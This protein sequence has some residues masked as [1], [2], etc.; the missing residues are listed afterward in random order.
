MEP[1]VL[2]TGLAFLIVAMGLL[3]WVRRRQ[4][5]RAP[6]LVDP[7]YLLLFQRC[8]FECLLWTIFSV[9]LLSWLQSSVVTTT[10]ITGIVCVLLG[11]THAGVT[12]SYFRLTPATPTEVGS[13][14]YHH[15]PLKQM[16][17]QA[18]LL[19]NGWGWLII[20]I[21][22]FSVDARLALALP[23]NL[24]VIL[25]VA[26]LY[27]NWK[28]WKQTCYGLQRLYQ[29]SLASATTIVLHLDS[30]S[31]DES[32]GQVPA[33]QTIQ[34]SESVELQPTTVDRREVQLPEREREIILSFRLTEFNCRQEKNIRRLLVMVIKYLA[35]VGAIIQ[36]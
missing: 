22:L 9:L 25:A 32:D 36:L 28:E 15:R 8:V 4:L 7:P 6:L 35:L 10:W 29:S 11:Q 30:A 34:L 18:S 21:S 16:Y 2:Q 14:V 13:T 12:L 26:E 19:L 33:M 3:Q 31:E 5:V 1:F 20:A 27:M 24:M 23:L 17:L